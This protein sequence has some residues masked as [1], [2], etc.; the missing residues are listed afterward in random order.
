[1]VATSSALVTGGKATLPLPIPA[2]PALA[3][4]RLTSQWLLLDAAA[5][6]GIRFSGG[7]A[8]KLW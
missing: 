8:L 3:G 5:P 2:N 7:G 6:G 4:A 1:M